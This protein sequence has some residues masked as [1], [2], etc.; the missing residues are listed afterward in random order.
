MAQLNHSN[1][2]KYKIKILFLFLIA[3]SKLV[4]CSKKTTDYTEVV[5]INHVTG[6][7]EKGEVIQLYEVKEKDLDLTTENPNKYSFI[8]EKTSDSDGKVYFDNLNLKRREKYKYYAS[9]V[10][11]NSY[12]SYYI[13]VKDEVEI[14]K[15]NLNT[16]N[17][18]IIA[19]SIKKLIIKPKVQPPNSSGI[20]FKVRAESEYLTL[21]NL[22]YSS[23]PGLFPADTATYYLSESG[24]SFTREN[25]PMGKYFITIIKID[26]NIL[27]TLT[28][29]IFC[30]RDQDYIYE[31]EF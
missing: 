25:T 14:D 21:H 10:L 12:S 17:E 1:L 5:I 23:Q 2:S 29:T 13:H 31:F 15:F 19:P 6:E 3:S 18:L 9:W 7:P 30:P 24:W 27:T 8:A 4:S 11:K 16:Q 28:D 26:N 22:Y 20:L